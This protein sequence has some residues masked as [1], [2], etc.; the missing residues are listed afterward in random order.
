MD[1]M[2]QQRREF[3]SK[4]VARIILLTAY[5]FAQSKRAIF[6]KARPVLMILGHIYLKTST[7]HPHRGSYNAFQFQGRAFLSPGFLSEFIL[8]LIWQYDCPAPTDVASIKLT[9]SILS[10]GDAEVEA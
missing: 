2:K 6:R 8:V 10:R 5:H 1:K 9:A 3:P 4:I 7:R